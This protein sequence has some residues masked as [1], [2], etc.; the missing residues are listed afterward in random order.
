MDSLNPMRIVLL[1]FV[2]LVLLMLVSAMPGKEPAQ[3]RQRNI[4]YALV[5][6]AYAALVLVY[7]R[8]F[9]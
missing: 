3:R 1:V 4:S 8:I 6:T 9:E 7:L 5:C 2:A